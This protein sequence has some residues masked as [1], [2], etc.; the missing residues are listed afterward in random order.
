MSGA[1]EEKERL[2]KSVVSLGTVSS[3]RAVGLVGRLATCGR[4]LASGIHT[5]T[6]AISS[7]LLAL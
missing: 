2:A 7:E 4:L 5:Y 3:G 1:E 6:H